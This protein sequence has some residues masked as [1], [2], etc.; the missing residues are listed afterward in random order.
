MAQKKSGE[1]AT[2]T[3]LPLLL[4]AGG[5]ETWECDFLGHM[6]VR[7]YAERA[8][9]GWAPFAAA[10]KLPNAF[11]REAVSTLLPRD[12]HLRCHREIRPGEFAIMRGGV[13]EIGE[14]YVVLYQ[15]LRKGLAG[16]EI[17][18]TYRV[19]LEHVEAKTGKPFHWSQKARDAMAQYQIS[20][21][22]KHGAARSFDLNAP[23]TPINKA[24]AQE[25]NVPLVAMSMQQAHECDSLGRMRTEFILG[26]QSNSWSGLAA[27]FAKEIEK[28]LGESGYNSVF[29]GAL[30]E[31]R[32]TPRQWPKAGDVI[33]T[34]CGLI[35]VNPKTFRF[36]IWAIDSVS[37]ECFFATDSVLV[38]FD[39]KA[40][41]AFE[42][43]EPYQ[44]LM[45]KYVVKGLTI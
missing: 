35:E 41:K 30:V 13:A 45:K 29:S 36:I 33:Q 3:P 26:R 28:I 39:I 9:Q 43:P 44:T 21:I 40:R 7:Y 24:R 10:I 8:Q 19:V 4:W 15:E 32:L 2:E 22:P 6:N 23:L 34:Y 31:T 14:D 25:L 18:A 20:A 17:A 5:C 16:E 38:N 12:I 27:P 1:P 42:G 37:G 11:H